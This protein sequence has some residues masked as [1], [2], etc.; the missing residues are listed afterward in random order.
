VQKQ[1]TVAAGNAA[2][3]FGDFQ[4]TAQLFS[5]NGAGNIY[6]EVWPALLF[7]VVSKLFKLSLP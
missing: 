1:L 3:M 7:N 5:L 2:A 6:H 4:T